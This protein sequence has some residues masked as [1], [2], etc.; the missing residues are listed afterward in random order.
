MSIDG[1]KSRLLS[2]FHLAVSL[3][4]VLGLPLA[5]T[6]AAH[7]D[8]NWITAKGSHPYQTNISLDSCFT[9]ALLDAKRNAMSKAGLERLSTNQLEICAETAES[10]NCDLHQE[11][12]NYFDGGYIRETQ[13]TLREEPKTGVFRECI[14]TIKADVRTYEQST[15][16]LISASANIT[17]NKVKIDGQEVQIV[18]EVS[19]NSTVQLLGWYPKSSGDVYYKIVPNQF[20]ELT[21]V[22]G[23]FQI[24]S[25]EAA[26]KYALIAE[27]D[28]NLEDQFASEVLAVLVT[29]KD[30]PLIDSER[31]EDLFSRLDAFGRENWKMI[32][33]SYTIA[34]D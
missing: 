15:N 30:F 19:A 3:V 26:T 10:A 21:N 23:K 9:E 17:G 12:L 24:P 32:K 5:F 8:E 31:S 34:R 16:P 13:V 22:T 18:G 33:V 20:E 25:K 6:S 1:L 2:K 27:F 4:G 14:I 28:E 11:T 29:N 7:S